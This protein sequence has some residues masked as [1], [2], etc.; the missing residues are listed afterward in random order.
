MDEHTV[1]VT[2]RKTQRHRDRDRDTETERQRHRDTEKLEFEVLRWN[3]SII[4]F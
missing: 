4:G 2:L 3:M 1:A